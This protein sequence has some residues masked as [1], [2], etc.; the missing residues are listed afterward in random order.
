MGGPVLLAEAGSGQDFLGV[1]KQVI[2]VGF[3]PF[4]LPDKMIS[5]REGKLHE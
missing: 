1:D 4:N 2:L 3:T 5:H